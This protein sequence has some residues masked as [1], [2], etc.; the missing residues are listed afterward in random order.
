MATLNLTTQDL[1]N[2][3]GDTISET[4]EIHRGSRSVSEG[5]AYERPNGPPTDEEIDDFVAHNPLFGDELQEQ[6]VVPGLLGFS[7]TTAQASKAWIQEFRKN[8]RDW[9]NNSSW[10]AADL[11][12]LTPAQSQLVGESELWLPTGLSRPNWV[13]SSPT[14]VMM[15]ADL[16]RSGGALSELSWRNFEELIGRL[17]ESEGW[18]VDVTRPSKDGGIDVIALRDDAT[19]GPIKSLWQAKRYGPSRKVRLAEVREFGGI[20]DFDR[21]TKGVIVTTSRLTAGALDWIRR[22][23]FRLD[24]KDAS[25][26][27]AWIRANLLR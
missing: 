13:S 14:A 26:M 4:I 12:W 23:K 3:I 17:L 1:R 6:L 27:E 9:S 18:V 19:L 2:L 8:A 16:L 11:P 15:A 25:R 22:D 10:L 21:A 20:V 24:Y 5:S 7:N